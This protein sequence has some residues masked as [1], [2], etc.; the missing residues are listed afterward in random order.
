MPR[1]KLLTQNDRKNRALLGAIALGMTQEGKSNE[2]MIAGLGMSAA[3]WARRKKD[4]GTF[5]VAEIRKIRALLPG[6]EIAI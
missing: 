2:D 5:T 6:A 1:I 3:T 4:P